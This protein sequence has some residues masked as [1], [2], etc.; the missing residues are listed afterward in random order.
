MAAINRKLLRHP[1]AMDALS[2]AALVLLTILL[3]RKVLVLWLTYDDANILRT[4]F[5]FP[6]LDIFKNAK[7]WPQQLF[8]P[9]LIV[10]FHVMRRLFGFDPSRF[11][12]LEIAIAA[13]TITLVYAAVRQFLDWKRS[14]AA[15]A[16]FALGPPV[17]SVVTQLSTVH[18]F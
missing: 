3:Y 15:A 7:V 2:I 12:L 5:D 16:L 4:T 10:A 18:Y 13:I 17:C 8:P 6:F 1:A 14:L 9:L 11:Y